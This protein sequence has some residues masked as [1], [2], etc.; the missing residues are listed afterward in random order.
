M[1]RFVGAICMALIIFVARPAEAENMMI[2]TEEYPPLSFQKDGAGTGASVEIVREILRRL[3]EPDTIQFLP[4]AR[5]Y[6][7][8]KTKENVILF[9][10]N[11]TRERENLFHWVG[12][13]CIARNGFYRRKGSGIQLDTV[14][15]AKKVRSIATYRDDAREQ[16]LESLGFNNI[17]SSNSALSNIK[18]LMAG[19]V[20]LWFYD[21]LGIPFVADQA[22][23]NLDDLDLALSIDEVALYIAVS[24]QTAKQVAARWQAELDE[25]KADG[26]F[27]AISR[28]WIDESSIPGSQPLKETGPGRQWP[29]RIYTEDSPP[30]NYLENGK[31]AGMAV[32]IVKEIL[33]R[34]GE[35]VQIEFVPWARGYGT[36]LKWPNVALF[37]TTR[38]P[39]RES[40][41]KWVGPLYVQQWGFYAKKGTTIRIQSFEEAKKVASIGTYRDDAK[42]QFLKKQ[43][44]TN[45]VSTNRNTSNINH[46]LNG[47]IELWVSSDFNMP[48]LAKQ[49]GVN[50]EQL[51][52]VYTFR[53]V[54]NYIAFSSGTRD[55]IVNAWQQAFDSM[56]SDG[57][58]RRIVN[59][60]PE[61]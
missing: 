50:P 1:L 16:M 60:R 39:Q 36:T 33:S 22:G 56:M 27:Y 55:E 10:T 21:N 28:K 43:G 31:P 5:G 8:L 61:E 23:V 41:F 2:I 6:N 32:E 34:L 59:I 49:A 42:E 58:F 14:D 47:N 48:Y 30:A 25:M 53:T 46:L 12:P 19:R 20:D 11:R 37:S 29:I 35:E 57:T 15:D 54:E 13:L 17:D 40:L 45:L 52:H 3:G 44:F 51:E 24:K 4:W 18:K 9:S 26:T 7:L 38:L